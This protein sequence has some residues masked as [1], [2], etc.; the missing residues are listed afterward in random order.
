[1]HSMFDLPNIA[2]VP[3][4]WQECVFTFAKPSPSPLAMNS[5]QWLAGLDLAAAI[6]T[7][8]HLCAVLCSDIVCD[9]CGN[10]ALPHIID[11]LLH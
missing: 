5:N 9:V 10:P 7:S 8:S 11:R 2:K 1:M 3:G 4:G 6:Q